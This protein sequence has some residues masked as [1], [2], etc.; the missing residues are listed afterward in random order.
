MNFLLF[1]TPSSPSPKNNNKKQKQ[2]FL[3]YTKIGITVFNFIQILKNNF[4]L[5]NP[6]F[7]YLFLKRKILVIHNLTR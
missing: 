2:T 4:A 6:L 1:F 3:F 5:K 7:I